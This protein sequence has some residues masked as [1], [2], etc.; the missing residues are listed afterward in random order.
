VRLGA[1]AAP[2][3]PPGG[4][5]PTGAFPPAGID[6]I[7]PFPPA[8][9]WAA[10]ATLILRVGLPFLATVSLAGWGGA[11]LESRVRRLNIRLERRALTRLAA[12]RA[13]GW[14]TLAAILLPGLAGLLA[15]AAAVA[16][17]RAVQG[18]LPGPAL[19]GASLATPLGLILWPLLGIGLGSRAGRGFPSN[20]RSFAWILGG[21]A[22]G[23]FLK[24][25]L[26]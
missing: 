9:T 18:I 19:R 1:G 22:V 6:G 10:S 13:D 3:V 21:A 11:V 14:G 2:G 8:A 17:G 25:I 20:L 5:L 12:G 7:V 24:W 15:A 23:V 16:L 26:T 4:L